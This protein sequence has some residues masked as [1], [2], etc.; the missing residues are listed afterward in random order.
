MPIVIFFVM[1][2]YSVATVEL[3]IEDRLSNQAVQLFRIVICPRV[4]NDLP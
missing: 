3:N 4:L 1:L 2:K